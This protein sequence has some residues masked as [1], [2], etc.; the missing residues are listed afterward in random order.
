MTCHFMDSSPQTDWG[1]LYQKMALMS[2]YLLDMPITQLSNYAIE[3][4]L[5][6]VLK[7]EEDRLKFQGELGRQFM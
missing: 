5:G 6:F 1:E 3:P 2:H 4:F 7:V